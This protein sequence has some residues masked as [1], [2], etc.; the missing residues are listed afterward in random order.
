MKIPNPIANYGDVVMVVNY[1][2]KYEP[3][4]E[5]VVKRLSYENSFGDFSW[6]Y[7]VLLSRRSKA[8]N[9]IWLYVGNKRIKYC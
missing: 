9:P 2:S 1:R 7:N 3:W 6:S 5:G 4:E 8:G